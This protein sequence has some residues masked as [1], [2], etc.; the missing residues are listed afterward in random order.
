MVER[1]LLL[2]PDNIDFRYNFACA[3]F[4]E[5]TGIELGLDHLEYVF[6]RAVGSI[7]RRA[8]I[9]PDLDPVRE[10]PRFKAMYGAAME[11]IARL[12]A[13]KAQTSPPAAAAA[14]PRS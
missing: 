6:A 11:R 13:E 3:L 12:D 5:P 8:D 1:V 2:A 7:I 14:P 9:D 4:A 10:H